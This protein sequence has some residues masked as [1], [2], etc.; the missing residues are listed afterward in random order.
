MRSEV[1]G[2]VCSAVE[3]PSTTYIEILLACLL[4]AWSPAAT[5]IFT[6][7]ETDRE[8][9]SAVLSIFD[10]GRRPPMPEENTDPK[11]WEQQLND[12]DLSMDRGSSPSWLSY[13]WQYRDSDVPFDYNAEAGKRPHKMQV[14]NARLAQALLAKMAEGLSQNAAAK[15]LGIGSGAASNALRRYRAH[16]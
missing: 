8:S 15:A 12:A 3:V 2:E 9:G 4:I 16:T 7:S 11:Y 1:R 6:E 14:E 10:T 13:G 5:S